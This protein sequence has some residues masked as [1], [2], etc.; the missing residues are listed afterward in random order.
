MTT[1]QVTSET[2]AGALVGQTFRDEQVGRFEIRCADQA[3]GLRA[4]AYAARSE[5][6]GGYFFLAFLPWGSELKS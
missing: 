1:I 4:I 2:D 6:A 5:E 3:P